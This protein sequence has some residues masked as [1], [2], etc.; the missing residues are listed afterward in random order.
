MIE[1]MQHELDALLDEGFALTAWEPL[2]IPST[3][4]QNF[5]KG[6]SSSV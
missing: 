1:T 5:F 4:S 6:C 2:G 3:H